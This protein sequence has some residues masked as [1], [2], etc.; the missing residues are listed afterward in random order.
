MEFWLFEGT[1]LSLLK[2]LVPVQLAQLDETLKLVRVLKFVPSTS[3]TFPRHQVRIVPIMV[4]RL[5]ESQP[6]Y[7]VTLKEPIVPITE[8]RLL[9]E[10]MAEPATRELMM[11]PSPKGMQGDNMLAVVVPRGV[12][13]LAGL[14]KEYS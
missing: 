13:R 11:L 2:L 7:S 8:V 5:P 14:E 10:S 9:R 12:P 6:S 3:T 4:V 1:Q